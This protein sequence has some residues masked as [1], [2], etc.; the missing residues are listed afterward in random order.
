MKENRAEEDIQLKM[1]L[2]IVKYKLHENK[3]NH[4]NYNP[5]FGNVFSVCW[6]R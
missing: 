6:V 1:D 5:Y 4:N 3:E 2:L